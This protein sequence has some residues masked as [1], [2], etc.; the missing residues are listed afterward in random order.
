MK[1]LNE[2]TE[3]L[4]RVLYYHKRS[5]CL[6]KYGTNY[7]KSDEWGDIDFYLMDQWI[8]CMSMLGIHY[9]MVPQVTLSDFLGNPDVLP[10]DQLPPSAVT[11]EVERLLLLLEKNGFVLEFLTEIPAHRVY[12]FITQQLFTEEVDAVRNHSLRRHFL[13]ENF[14]DEV[15][16]TDAEYWAEE[17]LIDFFDNSWDGVEF[18]LSGDEDFNRLGNHTTADQMKQRMA[19]FHASHHPILSFSANTINRKVEGDQATV[20][21]AV[22]WT[23]LVPPGPMLTTTTGCIRFHMKRRLRIGWSIS[24]FA[25]PSWL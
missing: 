24:D 22:T 14:Q 5:E 1:I 12:R 20:T 21:L 9:V 18:A 8:P 11:A 25:W 2:P 15:N 10:L 7:M 23:S 13:Y 16:D 17:F 3:Y 4:E 19:D 6:Q